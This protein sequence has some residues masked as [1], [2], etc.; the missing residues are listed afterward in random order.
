M[1]GSAKQAGKRPALKS[2]SAAVRE[3]TFQRATV[4]VL[5]D[6]KRLEDGKDLNDA[7]L[8][9]FVK[10][11]QALIPGSPSSGAGVQAPV[12][13]LG[14]HFY[15]V[16]R[17]GGVQDGRAG[18]KNVANWAKRRLGKGGLFADGV[19]A[20]AVP[21]NEVLRESYDG[22]AD[23]Q[24]KHW[25]LALLLNPRGVGRPD[26]EMSLLCLDSFVRA[27]TRYDPPIRACRAGGSQKG[28]YVSVAGLSRVGFCVNVSFGAGGD[29]TAGPLSEPRRSCLRA[30]GREFPSLELDLKVGKSGG[31]GEPGRFDGT[32]GFKLDRRGAAKTVGCY[33]LCYGEPTDDYQPQIGLRMGEKP[34]AFQKE[35]SRYLGG[36]L[37]REWEM[38]A[39]T[40]AQA[41]PQGSVTKVEEA[42]C[43]PGVPQQETSH[44]CGFF[45]LEQILRALQLSASELRELATASSVELAM[46][47]WPSQRQV[48]R[49]KAMLRDG[50][51]AL[52]AAARQAGSGD[53]EMLLK[54]LN[55]RER[56][57]CALHEGG[58][59][60][61]RGFERWA[62]GDWDLSPSASRSR[63]RR[64]DSDSERCQRE[65]KKKKRKKAKRKG[66]STESEGRR[67]RRTLSRSRSRKRGK[68]DA[69]SAQQLGE[70]RPTFTKQDL[71]KAPVSTLRAWCIQHGVLP[72]VAVERGDLVEPLLPL[73]APSPPA[74]APQQPQ[75]SQPQR[76]SQPQPQVHQPLRTEPG[77]PPGLFTRAD[78][79]AMPSKTLRALCADRGVLPGGPVERSE[80]IQ[81]L[82]P[83]AASGSN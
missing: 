2:M 41:A 58:A 73:A 44:D 20:L 54:D 49:R 55:L 10:L 23:T 80:L 59:N 71:D 45:I 15:D 26:E 29:G 70:Q 57:R 74:A 31:D 48:F 19:G 53:V 63:E 35:V 8:D 67:R 60:F 40:P 37:A 27:E 36:Y 56:I 52:F 30:G 17:K 13:Y 7:L 4:S 34:T 38:H 83:L 69:S 82:A 81:A 62:D 22:R 78:L 18:H 11:G 12:A 25:W 33:N 75:L 24:E 66:G 65:K 16:L 43:L 39:H 79:D 72:A 64:S 47:P 32:L 6:A 51:D 42:I 46:L 1:H 77:V 50:M 68:S 21:V 3:I 14:S 28:Y 61:S 76:Q 9:F 5:H